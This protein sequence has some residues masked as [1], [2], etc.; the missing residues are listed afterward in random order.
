MKKNAFKSSNLGFNFARMRD[1]EQI[2][3]QVFPDIKE[4]LRKFAAEGVLVKLKSVHKRNYA[5]LPLGG[6]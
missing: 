3:L 4:P 6:L 1:S 5:F 2:L